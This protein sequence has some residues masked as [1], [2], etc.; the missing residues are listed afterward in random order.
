MLD[1]FEEIVT[2][3]LFGIEDYLS[4][5]ALRERMSRNGAGAF[6][7]LTSVECGNVLRMNVVMDNTRAGSASGVVRLYQQLIA[8]LLQ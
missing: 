3:V 6:M 1:L 7:I 4:P 2:P 8:G 5:V